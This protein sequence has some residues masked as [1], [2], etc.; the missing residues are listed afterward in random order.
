MAV[1]ISRSIGIGMKKCCGGTIS[2]GGGG[3]GGATTFTLYVRNTLSGTPPS[4]CD[5]FEAY[6]YIDRNDGQGFQTA[7]T[8]IKTSNNAASISNPNITVTS[9]DKVKVEVVALA[10]SN[11]QC[12][13]DGYTQ[14]DVELSTGSFTGALT[15][16][17]LVSSPNAQTY[18][19]PPGYFNP[20]QGVEDFINLKGFVL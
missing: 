15:P 17:F 18:P 4:G 8:V 2:G 19:T 1:G 10:I 14:T 13:R 11:V 12:N 20:V 5:A 7:C 6:V 16:R 3:G 9:T